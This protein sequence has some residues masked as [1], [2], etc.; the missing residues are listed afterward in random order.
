MI[1]AAERPAQ[2][3]NDGA[4]S[5]SRLSDHQEIPAKG[6]GVQSRLAMTGDADW[7]ADIGLH[8]SSPLRF[9]SV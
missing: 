8:A 7:G 1:L 3:V 6:S 2:G 4:L 5:C 9:C